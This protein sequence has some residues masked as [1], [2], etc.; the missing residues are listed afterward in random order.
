[1]DGLIYHLSQ[2]GVADPRAG[3]LSLREQEYDTIEDIMKIR[4]QEELLALLT[5]AGFKH[6][7]AIAFRDYC[8]ELH[9]SQTG[10]T[11]L[12]PTPSQQQVDSCGWCLRNLDDVVVIYNT[13]GTI[14]TVAYSASSTDRSDI[15]EKDGKFLGVWAPA[16]VCK[17]LCCFC[18]GPPTGLFGCCFKNT[19][20]GLAIKF[21]VVLQ[22]VRSILAVFICFIFIGPRAAASGFIDL[23]LA[24]MV[25]RAV[26]NNSQPMI[27]LFALYQMI[28]TMVSLA[29]VF[30]NFVCLI[31]FSRVLFNNRL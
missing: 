31:P 27:Q 11:N 28:Q 8:V 17:C 3:A 30:L 7:S 29:V 9:T 24:L 13:V 21:L 10:P 22:I 26:K 16:L 1:M 14:S 19:S 2:A 23:I 20:L 12:A 18:C 15:L 4:S 25:Y 5:A 6:K